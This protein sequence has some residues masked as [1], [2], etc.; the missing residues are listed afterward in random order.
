M[1][2]PNW[3]ERWVLITLLVILFLSVYT[4]ASGEAIL[5]SVVVYF[6]AMCR[7]FFKYLWP[8]NE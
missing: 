8:F 1:A 6:A 4:Q 5:F 2:V 3:K 7:Y